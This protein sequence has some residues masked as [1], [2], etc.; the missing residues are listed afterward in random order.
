VQPAS[1]TLPRDGVNDSN[2]WSPDLEL[3]TSMEVS[4]HC[5]LVM[6]LRSLAVLPYGGSSVNEMLLRVTWGS[7]LFLPLVRVT[8]VTLIVT[9]TDLLLNIATH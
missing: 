5:E 8:C 7:G 6:P 1:D 2:C 3:E 4:C 9:M